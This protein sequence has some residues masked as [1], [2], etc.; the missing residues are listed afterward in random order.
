MATLRGERRLA[1]P[2]ALAAFG[3]SLVAG[4][5]LAV[6]DTADPR[7]AAAAPTAAAKPI[8]GAFVGRVPRT[9]AYIAVVATRR[10]VRAY[11]C[12]GE[13][14]TSRKTLARWLRIKR[15]GDAVHLENRGVVIDATVTRSAVRGTVKLPG[16]RAR[17]FNARRSRGK[18]GVYR[19]KGRSGGS[20][21]LGGW[22]ILRNGTGRGAVI[23]PD[24]PACQSWTSVP[25]RKLGGRGPSDPQPEENLDRQ[26]PA[27]PEVC[28]PEPSE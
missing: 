23:P 2:A 10:T 20:G 14:K 7:R 17:S 4:S 12:D 5:A 6:S 15:T 25:V 8:T 18:A 9:N 3:A 16:R 26:I 24:P 13:A 22:I 19:A 21:Y 11:V 28:G 27:F 1:L